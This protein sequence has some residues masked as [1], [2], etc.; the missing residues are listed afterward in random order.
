RALLCAP[1]FSSVALAANLLLVSGDDTAKKGYLPGI[2]NGTT[3][4]TVALAEA[5]GRWDEAGVTLPATGQGDGWALSGEKLYVLDGHIADLILVAGRT[6]AGVSLFAVEKG[7]P[8]LTTT[9]LSTMD[10]T[11]KQARVAFDG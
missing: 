6:G 7:A 10:Q 11:R 3:L 2:A 4:A 5:S 1:F 8:G 9:P